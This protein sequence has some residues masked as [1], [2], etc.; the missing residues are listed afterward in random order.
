MKLILAIVGVA[1]VVF[2]FLFTLKQNS[3]E[4]AAAEF[5]NALTK[6][7]PQAAARLSYLENPSKPL[8]EQWDY[9]FNKAG[10]HFLFLVS[11][12]GR[13]QR[14]SDDRATLSVS[15]Y[16]FTGPAD[17]G[18]LPVNASSNETYELPMIKVD[19]QWKV[20][21]ASLTRRFYPYLPK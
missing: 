18:D 13:V 10:K 17:G 5:L 3:P 2:A 7:D 14:H 1:V 20:D 8:S 11:E 15:Y 12:V 6:R 9:A 4:A 19:G 16:E 21:L